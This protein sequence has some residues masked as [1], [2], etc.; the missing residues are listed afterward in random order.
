MPD[1]V[2]SSAA[3]PS[4]APRPAVRAIDLTKV[5]GPGNTA[6]HAHAGVTVDIMEGEFTAIMGA[7]RLRQLNP[8][9]LHGWA[10]RPHGWARLCW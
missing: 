8:D 1:P 9:A 4:D 10:G 2:A 5:Y 6:V 7:I 3:S